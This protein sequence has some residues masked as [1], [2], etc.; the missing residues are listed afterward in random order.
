[1]LYTHEV[2]PAHPGEFS[3][4]AFLNNKIDL[5]EAETISNIINSSSEYSHDIIINNLNNSLRKNI[6]EI[7]KEIIDILSIIEHELDFSEDEID[8]ITN[9]SILN[10]VDN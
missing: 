7:N 6:L 4:R 1:M 3:Y 5:I 9:E 2:K 10:I 8:Y